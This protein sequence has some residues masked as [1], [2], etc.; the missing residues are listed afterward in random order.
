MPKQ[1][2]TKEMIVTAAFEI[3]RKEGMEQILVKNIAEKLEC[4]VQPIY[5]YCQNIE[6]LRQDVV[7][8]TLH[9]IHRFLAAHTDTNDIFRSTGRAYIRLAEEEPHL[10]R[11]FILHKRNEISSLKD[12]YQKESS[13]HTA[14]FIA[15]QMNLGLEQAQILHMNMMIYNIGLGTIFSVTT[16]GITADEIYRQQELAFEAFRSQALRAGRQ[17]PYQTSDPAAELQ[18]LP[19]SQNR[20]E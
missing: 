18:N 16:S 7:A 5:S 17:V 13:P 10:F 9:F 15:K 1:R 8:E 11:I 14:E 19:E 20:K 4:S 2:I 6:G 3:A 12:L